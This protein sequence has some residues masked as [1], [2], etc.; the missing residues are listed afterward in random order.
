MTMIPLITASRFTATQICILKIH[1]LCSDTAGSDS[2]STSRIYTLFSETA[3]KRAQQNF[4]QIPS[5]Q[6]HIGNLYSYTKS[7]VM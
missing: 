2:K 1:T 6:R 3:R 4:G 5:Y 7:S